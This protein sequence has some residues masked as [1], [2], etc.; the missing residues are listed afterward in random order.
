VR[1]QFL[2]FIALLLTPSLAG[3]IQEDE[4]IDIFPA[5]SAIADNGELYDN[6]RMANQSYIV[7][8]SAEWC[9]RP[10]YST[11]HSMWNAQ[12]ELP[13]LVMSTDPAERAGGL[14]LQQWHDSANAYDDDD[15]STNNELTS[16]AF[17]K[18]DEVAV[19][20]EINTP[21]TMFFINSNGEVTDIHEGKLD[22]TDLILSYW[23]NANKYE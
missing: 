6:Q 15:N 1:F 14:T 22:D 19:L 9:N 18:G 7:M 4:E 8:F 20:L 10:C 11:M 21:G 2:I 16:Y 12:A 13:V 3:C 17:M 5:F 23:A